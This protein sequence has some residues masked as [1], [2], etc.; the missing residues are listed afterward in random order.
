MPDVKLQLELRPV[1]ITVKGIKSLGE[2]DESSDA[3]EIYL[4]VTAVDLAAQP[5]PNV[6]TIMTG[7]WAS[8]DQGEF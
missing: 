3:D 7:V 5:I 6:R 4:I 2:S 8:V 1:T